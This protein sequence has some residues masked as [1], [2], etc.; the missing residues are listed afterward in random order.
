MPGTSDRQSISRFRP[1][2][3]REMSSRVTGA[4]SVSFNP[5]SRAFQPAG[6]G[7]TAS[8]GGVERA[9]SCPAELTDVAA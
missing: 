3:P 6:Y 2:M 8:T 4:G 1:R 5:D 7:T 9:L